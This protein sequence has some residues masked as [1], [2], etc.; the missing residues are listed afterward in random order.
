MRI[1]FVTFLRVNDTSGVVI[2]TCEEINIDGEVETSK[3]L[4][5][6]MVTTE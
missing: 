6:S 5:F 4:D 3:I 2:D 1:A